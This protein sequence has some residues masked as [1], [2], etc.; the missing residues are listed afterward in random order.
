[1]ELIFNLSDGTQKK[2]HHWQEVLADKENTHGKIKCVEWKHGKLI[3]NCPGNNCKC[4]CIINKA[5][6][7]SNG[8]STQY[9][10]IGYSNDGEKFRVTFVSPTGDS[11]VEERDVSTLDKVQIFHG[12]AS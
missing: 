3:H 7:F 8:K 1:M 9:M 2:Y 4:F 5:R 6:M 10:G 11:H 12:T